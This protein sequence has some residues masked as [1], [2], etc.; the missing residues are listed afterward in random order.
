MI[1]NT[2]PSERRTQ[3]GVVVSP[4]T[5]LKP[6]ALLI[7]QLGEAV[8]SGLVDEQGIIGPLISSLSQRY[9]YLLFSFFLFILSLAT[10]IEA[11]GLQ[12]NFYYLL[13]ILGPVLSKGKQ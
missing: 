12:L 5:H 3:W 13:S 9:L 2:S 8:Q 10:R 11:I 4:S 7:L 6:S 1:M